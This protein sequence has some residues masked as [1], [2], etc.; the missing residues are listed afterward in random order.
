MTM[1]VE[2]RPWT[3]EQ[4]MEY[5]GLKRGHLA[6]LRFRGVGPAFHKPTARTVIY[7][8]VDVI[9]WWNKCRRTITG[10]AQPR[11]AR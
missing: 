6:Q 8:D 5:T 4:V 10:D 2:R 1:K 9:E 11:G 7:D 3:I